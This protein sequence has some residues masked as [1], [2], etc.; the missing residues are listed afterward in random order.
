MDLILL[1]VALLLGFHF[2]MN[3]PLSSTITAF[4][5]VWFGALSLLWLTI[6]TITDNYG[7]QKA[8]RI[9]PSLFATM[10]TLIITGIIYSLFLFLSPPLLAKPTL[11]LL[12]GIVAT[13]M[14]VSWRFFYATFLV[15][16]NFQRRVLIERDG[17]AEGIIA[18]AIREHNSSYTIIGQIEG[19]A[20]LRFQDK[21]GPSEPNKWTNLNGFI[22]RH[23]IT[24]IVLTKPDDMQ[25]DKLQAVLKCFE[26]GV[27]IVPMPVLFEEITGRI[28]VEH[29][30]N[31]WLHALPIDRE[32]SRMYTMVKRVMDLVFA[33]IGLII[34][35]PS[36][37]F[38][39]LAIKLESSGPIFYRPERLGKGGKPFRLWKFR[40]MVANADRIGDPTFTAKKD[41]R[42]TRL[43]RILRKIHLDELPQFMNII[44]GDMS[45]VGPR[46]ER[47]VAELE[48]NIPYY[49]TRNAVK[50][51]ATGWA[52]VKQGYAEGIEETLIKLQYD[53]YYIKHQSLSL[54]IRII[55]KSILHIL[56]MNGR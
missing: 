43:G 19:Y 40:T 52:L 2:N 34:V 15:K 31:S 37:L 27:R 30:S 55:C 28:P 35:S 47:Y 13:V 14:L 48:K 33:S 10:E 20:V 7:V 1:N 26:Q 25:P 53:L 3:M 8:A 39:A 22:Q 11:S 36:F 45:L 44:V 23:N 41:Q 51:G 6:S 16:A 38:L 18:R 12:I 46:P 5:P 9:I 32:A 49:R 50:P 24:D 56:N 21:N 54:D 17:L 42:I 29:I 4:H